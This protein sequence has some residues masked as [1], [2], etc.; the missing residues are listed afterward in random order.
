MHCA[1][2]S[3]WLI[4]NHAP[5][6]IVSG[7]ANICGDVL[8]VDAGLEAVAKLKLSP[9]L[10]IGDFDS[11]PID[12]LQQFKDVAVHKHE[13]RKNETDTELALD[14]C[15]QQG[16]RD[17]VICNDMQGRFDHSLAI[18][19][20]LLN[21]HRKGI[22]A[23]IESEKQQIFFLT[24]HTALEGQKGDLLSLLC[25]GNEAQFKSSSGLEYPLDGL[26]LYQHQSR[27]ISNVFA[28]NRIEIEL[29][30]GEVLAVYSPHR[31]G[32]S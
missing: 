13:Q 24:L 9:K 14:W 10:I 29:N 28:Q 2:K 8:A 20:N 27:G 16:Y 12:L 31:I 6:R 15:I 19:Q 23:R 5:A 26:Q 3:A 22:C 11:L 18:I 17:I 7:Y 4:T 30:T 21:L 32:N 1:K 25:Y